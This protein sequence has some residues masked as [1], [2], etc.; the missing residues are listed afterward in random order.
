[1]NKA[2]FSIC[3]CLQFLLPMSYSIQYIDISPLWLDVLKYFIVFDAIVNEIFFISFSD[4]LFLVYRNITALWMLEWY[5]ATIIILL[6]SHSTFLLESLDFPYIKWCHLPTKTILLFPFQIGC[7][8]F[9]YC[10]IALARTLNTVLNRG[11][12]NGHPSFISDLKFS[13]LNMV[14]PVGLSY[15]NCIMLR[16]ISS[17]LILLKVFIMKGCWILSNLFLHL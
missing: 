1:M 8:L 12:E 16:Y 10:L 4:G 11:S 5:P 13:S 7:L 15:K 9:I 6:I 2:Y 3:L 14:L 17:I